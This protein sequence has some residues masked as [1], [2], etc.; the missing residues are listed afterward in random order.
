MRPAAIPCLVL[1]LL[2]PSAC[3][4]GSAADPPTSQHLPASSAPSVPSSGLGNGQFGLGTKVRITASGFDPQVLVTG[5]GL[6]VTW[7]NDSSSTQS[8]HFDNWGAAV[9]SGPIK[10]GQSWTFKADHTASVLYHSTY[11]PAFLGQ[12]QIQLTGN[13]NEPG[14]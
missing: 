1:A 8:V 5:M 4:S 12:L 9:D 11:H 10:P 14:G 7:T 6:R 2:L 13:G 3:S